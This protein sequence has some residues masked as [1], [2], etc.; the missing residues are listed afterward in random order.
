MGLNAKL[1]EYTQQV[2]LKTYDMDANVTLRP[3]ALLRYCQEACELHLACYDLT[4]E[5]MSKDGIVF[6]F[7]R[8]G[9]IIHRWPSQHDPVTI[10][11][12]ACGVVGVQ[13]YRSFDFYCG[14]EHLAEILQASVVVSTQEHKLL[15]PR[16]FLDYGVGAGENGGKRLDRL[17][18]P[19]DMPVVG[20]REI[21]Y[22][23]LDY[24]GHVNNSVYSDIFCDFVPGGMHGR[25]L[26]EF[27]IHY[28]MESLEG[29]VLQIQRQEK[30]GYIFMRGVNPRGISFEYQGKVE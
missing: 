29:E 3:S 7:T 24:N 15:R 26:R 6:V 20:E 4:H 22:S 9:G 30:D 14:E 2:Q 10:V 25:T 19:K 28:A 16:A 12:R 8:S 17:S 18:L 11:T 5:K 21:R 1:S 13:F 23:D 27:Q